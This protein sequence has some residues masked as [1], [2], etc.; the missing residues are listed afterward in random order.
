MTKAHRL[1]LACGYRQSPFRVV[2]SPLP[3]Q[4]LPAIALRLHFIRSPSLHRTA[5]AVAREDPALC[6]RLH[7]PNFR[8]YSAQ[9]S[10]PILD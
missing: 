5:Q 10:I 6:S 2:E 1:P 8:H 7:H 9:N 3:S 4:M